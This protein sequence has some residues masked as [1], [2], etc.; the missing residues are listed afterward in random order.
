[1]KELSFLITLTLCTLQ[2]S[3]QNIMKELS[4]LI[5]LTLWY[6]ATLSTKHHEGTILSY[7]TDSMYTAT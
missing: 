6:I 4:Y 5:T 2:L 7:H 3:G 1:M